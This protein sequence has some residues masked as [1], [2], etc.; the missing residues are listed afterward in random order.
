MTLF[1]IP[2]LKRDI[3]VEI[4]GFDVET[5]K[6]GS[7]NF[8]Y[9]SKPYGESIL[10]L[11]QED[12]INWLSEKKLCRTFVTGMNLAY[13][14]NSMFPIFNPERILGKTGNFI[15]LRLAPSKKE[16]DDFIIVIDLGSF[17][18]GIGLK[19]LAKK[20]KFEY[21]DIHDINH[22]NIKD[23]C[24]SHAKSSAQILDYIRNICKELGFEVKL[25]AA[26][27]ALRA[28][29]VS[30]LQPYDQIFDK[31]RTKEKLHDMKCKSLMTYKG[32]ACELFKKGEY[33]VTMIDV[34]SMYPTQML[35]NIPDMNNFNELEEKD[36]NLFIKNNEL[37]YLQGM[38]LINM[39]I[40]DINI[41]PFIYQYMNDKAICKS[42]NFSGWLNFVDIRYCIKLGA[43]VEY[44]EIVTFKNKKSIFIDYINYFKDMKKIERLKPFAKLML[45]SLYGKFAEKPHEENNFIEILEGE[46]FD[47]EQGYEDN[48]FKQKQIS[49]NDKQLL[50]INGKKISKYDGKIYQYSHHKYLHRGGK[51][52][53]SELMYPEHSYPLISSYIT[54]YAR[55]FLHET[56]KKLGY[57]NI[58][59]CDTDSIAFIGTIE[60]AKEKGVIIGSELGN[61]EL[62]WTGI[63]DCVRPKV[64]RYK[65]DNTNNWKYVIKGVPKNNMEDFWINGFQTKF[66]RP[67]KYFTSIRTGKKINEWVKMEYIMRPCM[68]K[69]FFNK[70]GSS[71]PYNDK[72]IPQIV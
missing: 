2:Q 38:A 68:Q 67:R 30:F 14:F 21:I 4:W 41:V 55:N 18:Q 23:A 56:M 9:A 22:P 62:K 16:K 29:Q 45:N 39:Q 5:N 20:F 52:D 60:E 49:D 34:V 25:T 28:F 33:H 13:D 7:F 63:I 47:I 15:S 65:E 44:L 6:D 48:G 24:L 32:G 17:F 10:F 11:K 64:Y 61:Y 35:K 37:N 72:D 8:A 54:S 36:F 50:D 31:Y 69:R 71:R 51:D 27:T 26:S 1:T 40:P 43:K 57:E 70:D 59:Y 46:I 19:D 58:V 3:D 12:A 42:G 66:S 53:E